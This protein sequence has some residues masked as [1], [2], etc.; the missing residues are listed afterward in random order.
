MKNQAFF[1]F[2]SKD[3]SKKFKVSSAAS[4]VG[5]LRVKKIPFVTSRGMLITRLSLHC[6]K[7]ELN[8]KI[9]HKVYKYRYRCH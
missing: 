5:A 2:F 8:Q 1:F 6:H 7:T 9:P 3:K 4:L